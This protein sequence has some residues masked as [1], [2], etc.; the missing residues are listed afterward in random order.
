MKKSLLM[1][2]GNPLAFL[3]VLFSGFLVTVGGNISH[4]SFVG[5]LILLF[6]GYVYLGIC[7]LLRRFWT[8]NHFLAEVEQIS[9]TMLTLSI[10]GLLLPFSFLIGMEGNVFGFIILPLAAIFTI[11]WIS[12]TLYAIC[13]K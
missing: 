13:K 3:M 2:A 9:T 7:A 6:L 10:I 1:S 5:V 12:Y 8:G 4:I 11:V